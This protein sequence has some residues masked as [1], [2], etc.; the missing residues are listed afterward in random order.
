MGKNAPEDEKNDR[1]E[2]RDKYWLELNEVKDNHVYLIRMRLRN[3]SGWSHYCSAI[4]VEIPKQVVDSKIIKTLSE[5]NMITEWL[6]K[7]YRKRQWKLLFRAS[8]NQFQSYQF[9]RKCDNKKNPTLVVVE[10][11]LKHVFGGFTVSPWN[12]NGNYGF[13]GQAFIFKVREPG[14]EKTKWKKQYKQ[15]QRTFGKQLWRIP[16]KYNVTQPVNAT[17]NGNGYGPTF[18]GGHDFYICNMSNTQTGSYSNAG[19]SYS[20]PVSNVFLAGSYNFMTKEYEV[21][22]LKK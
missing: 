13:D 10:T 20:C 12:Q 21:F 15:M 6:P 8:K 9:H 5:K 2:D 3:E 22:E 7:K 16:G 14:M 11:T 4:R 19:N 1:N 17:N 18:G